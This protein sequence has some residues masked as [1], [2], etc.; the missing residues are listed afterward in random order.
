MYEK[1]KILIVDDYEINRDILKSVCQKLEEYEIREAENGLEA[2]DIAEKWNPHVILM[3]IIMPEM[4]GFEASKII[5]S[6]YPNTI[7]IVVTSSV[8][9]HIEARF[10]SI[11]VTT[12]IHKPINKDLIR[13]KLNSFAALLRSKDK[14]RIYRSNVQALNPFTSDVRHF[15][16]VFF[17]ADAE[18]MMDFGMWILMRSESSSE[19]SYPK[20]DIIIELFYVLMSYMVKK[21]QKLEIVVE[22][23]FDE[24]FIIVECSLSLDSHPHIKELMN[25]LGEMSIC[26]DNKLFI[27]M[28]MNYHHIFVSAADHHILVQDEIKQES[29]LPAENQKNESD[30]VVQPEVGKEKRVLLEDEQ[31]LLRQSFS[32][33]ISAIDYI[34]DIGGD[35][36]DEINDLASLDDAWKEEILKIEMEPSIHTISHFVDNVLNQYTHAINSLFEFTALAYSLSALGTS[37]KEHADVLTEDKAKISKMIIL[38]D[39]LGH[40]LSAWREHIF[41]LKDSVD[42]HY[43][44]SS[45]FS[46]CIQI[47]GILSNKVV[48]EEDN[49]LEL[50]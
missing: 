38:L 23:N 7:I 18:S 9:H 36:L 4:D 25:A 35:V 40:D 39:H 28:G 11:G 30:G 10:A 17:I 47:E 3:D 34:N 1:L 26:Q 50:F 6:K 24:I 32:Q 8:D 43:L 31:T 42:I 21:E 29:Q 33:K 14:N 19:A 12:Y 48:E 13:F 37:M 20:V 15:K 46:S 27:R 5:K 16:T 45:F 41:E 2:I 44:D 22:E 49:D